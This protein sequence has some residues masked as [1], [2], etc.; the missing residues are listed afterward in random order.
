MDRLSRLHTF[1]SPTE[2][3]AA[4]KDV[5]RAGQGSSATGSIASK[6][7]RSGYNINGS[8][9]RVSY[10]GGG[11]DAN[12]VGL[13]DERHREGSAVEGKRTVTGGR[14]SRRLSSFGHFLR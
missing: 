12:G 14:S 10:S 13:E 7:F 2:A 9:S 6:I 3:A 11:G 8:N 1:L 5:L 4:L